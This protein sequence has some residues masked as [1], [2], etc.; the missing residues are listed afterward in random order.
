MA[1]VTNGRL[2]YEMSAID[3]TYPDIGKVTYKGSY[4]LIVPN[5]WAPPSKMPVKGDLIMLDGKQYRVLKVNKNIAEV[6]CMYAANANIA[7]NSVST[8]YN[9]YENSDIDTYCNNTFYSGLSS[10]MKNAIVDKTFIQDS[11]IFRGGSSSLAS[12]NAKYRN[13]DDGTITDAVLS[14]MKDKYHGGKSLT[15][16]CY[17]LSC[18]DVIDYLE[19]TTDMTS[20][21]TTLTY[22]NIWKMFWNVTTYTAHENIWLRSAFDADISSAYTVAGSQGYLI[23]GTVTSKYV[24]HSA[25]PAFQIDLSKV[26]WVKV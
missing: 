26:D 21:N 23:E 17:C 11:W 1:I 19:V 7:F 22:E 5:Q 10:T 6:L 13:I 2:E 14:L 3:V 15:R 16:H 24:V 12:Y 8:N 4:P 20:D 9:Y 18:Q 25:H